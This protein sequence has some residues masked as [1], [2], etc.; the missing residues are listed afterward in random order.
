MRHCLYNRTSCKSKSRSSVTTCP[1]KTMAAPFALCQFVRIESQSEGFNHDGGTAHNGIALL[2][3]LQK[4]SEHGLGIEA[5]IVPEAVLVQVGLQVMT[6]NA[7][8]NAPQPIFY[9]APES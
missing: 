7:V 9:Q 6:A 5:P 2:T 3:L 1:S 4:A 8:V